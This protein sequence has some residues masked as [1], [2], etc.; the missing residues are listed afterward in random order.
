MTQEYAMHQ[1]SC[2]C[3]AV[4]FE[5]NADLHAP[6]ACHCLQCRKY[7]GHYWASTDVYRAMLSIYGEENIT[8]YQSSEKVRRGFCSTCGSS[9]FWDPILKDKIAVA[10][11]S[12]DGPTGT[13]LAMHIFTSEKGDYYRIADGITQHLR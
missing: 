3:G 8:W 11:G 6:D 10:M 12:L 2:L 4:H 1:G 13:Q 7:S 5:I 9:L